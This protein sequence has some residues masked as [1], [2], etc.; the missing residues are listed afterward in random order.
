[1][2]DG[3]VDR[4]ASLSV[5]INNTAA[6]DGQGVQVQVQVGAFSVQLSAT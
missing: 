6:A 5:A 4:S 3:G 1:M 2:S